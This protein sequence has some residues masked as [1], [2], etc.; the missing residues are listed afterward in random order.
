MVRADIV[1]A[2]A[3]F[4][5]DLVGYI[6][7]DQGRK[8]VL[9][10]VGE[11]DLA[12]AKTP[13]LYLAA[14]RLVETLLAPKVVF[15]SVNSSFDMLVYNYR[16]SIEAN[17]FRCLNPHERLGLSLHL[18]GHMTSGHFKHP[19]GLCHI[20]DRV[21]LL[22]DEN[23]RNRQANEW[24]AHLGH[25]RLPQIDHPLTRIFGYVADSAKR[26]I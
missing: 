16:K 8:I 20:D 12:T 9:P 3:K 11:V 5:T 4:E 21:V 7:A 22:D 19:L 25:S 24:V 18:V 23:E 13:Q 14:Q 15:R 6:K 1:E 17:Q 26:K 10:R 2:G